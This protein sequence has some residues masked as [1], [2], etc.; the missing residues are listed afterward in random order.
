MAAGIDE[1]GDAGTQPDP[2]SVP[3]LG[4]SARLRGVL[5]L[6]GRG[7]G[8]TSSAVGNG[9]GRYRIYLTDYTDIFRAMGER[10][11][12]RV[13]DD[14]DIINLDWTD[15]KIRYDTIPEHRRY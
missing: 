2:P 9:E 11:L 10:I 6:A 3:E 4:R 8:E 5:V 14:M 15:G 1:A 7:Q 12:D 13:L